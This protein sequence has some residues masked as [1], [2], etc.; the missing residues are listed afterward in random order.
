MQKK[1][2]KK[3]NQKLIVDISNQ[4]FGRLIALKP[5][6]YRDYGRVMWE[7]KCDCGNIVFVRGSS[8]RTGNTKSCGCFQIESHR[9]HGM[10]KSRTYS[11]WSGMLQR[12]NNP[13]S[14]RYYQYGGKGIVVC[15]RWMK[16]EN[17]LTDMGERPE[18]KTIDRINNDGNYEPSNCRWATPL[19][20]QR[21]L[22]TNI[23]LK[24]NDETKTV[25]EIADI[26]GIKADTLRT[27]IKRHWSEER[28]FEP[29]RFIRR[30]SNDTRDK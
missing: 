20:Q 5:T 28:L 23:Q 1:R 21:N 17:F 9:K 2:I 26:V 8:L 6:E 10:Y 22:K 11:T 25:P 4:R 29:L 18:G 7:C 13:N 14:P 24:F 27:R 30:D 12:C 16:F 3:A 15:E 19:E